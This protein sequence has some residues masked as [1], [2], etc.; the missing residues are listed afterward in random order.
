MTWQQKPE[1]TLRNENPFKIVIW[2]FILLE[3]IV[4]FRF[5]KKLLKVV[6]TNLVPVEPKSTNE[7]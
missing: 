7:K 1:E 4:K 5:R 3:N 6:N 2:T